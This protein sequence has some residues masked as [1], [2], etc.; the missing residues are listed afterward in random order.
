MTDSVPAVSLAPRRAFYSGSS[1]NHFDSAGSNGPSGVELIFEVE[2][3]RF[4]G[5]ESGLDRSRTSQDLSEAEGA[6]APREEQVTL[7]RVGEPSSEPRVQEKDGSEEPGDP[8]RPN[9]DQ[10]SEPEVLEQEAEEVAVDSRVVAPVVPAAVGIGPGAAGI[11]QE[12]PGLVATGD[13]ADS[14]ATSTAAS[15]GGQLATGQATNTASPTIPTTPPPQVPL[16]SVPTGRNPTAA[17]AGQGVPGSG[18]DPTEVVPADTP[19]KTKASSRPAQVQAVEAPTPAAQQTATVL[20]AAVPGATPSDAVEPTA[21]PAAR[22]Q[23]AAPLPEPGLSQ[24]TGTVKTTPPEAGP[25][26]AE[27]PLSKSAPVTESIGKSVTGDEGVRSPTTGAVRHDS[28]VPQQT[29]PSATVLPIEQTVEAAELARRATTPTGNGLAGAATTAGA[30]PE[31][32]P[33]TAPHPTSDPKVQVAAKPESA[34]PQAADG[35]PDQPGK[36]RVDP[37]IVTSV[38]QRTIRADAPGEE[39][40]RVT[41]NSSGNQPGLLSEEDGDSAQ[42]DETR[43]PAI[44]KPLARA[45]AAQPASE[46]ASGGTSGQSGST[47]PVTQAG[48]PGALGGQPLDLHRV[49]TLR[50]PSGAAPRT[51]PTREIFTQVRNQIRPGMRELSIQ[52]KPA[53][54]GQLK[55]HFL[56]EGDALRVSVTAAR[57]EVV[58]ALKS[59]LS[60]FTQTLRDAGIELTSL[61]VNLERGGNQRHTAPGSFHDRSNRTGAPQSDAAA[62]SSTGQADRSAASSTDGA[63]DIMA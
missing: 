11:G 13:G 38:R 35:Q 58:A 42:R 6:N 45:L 8:A 25:V 19:G 14:T 44:P 49:S 12:D 27:P 43:Q 57:P 5:G 2:L 46:P 54:L 18:G 31:A 60:A 62:A 41:E 23:P 50:G 55:L 37:E 28:S 40:K 39:P 36:N 48:S 16:E 10:E 53:E 7:E 61:D 30:R 15:R 29:N 24:A 22:R 9:P 59:D 63:L 51:V 3:S 32:E 17:T 33:V 4:T 47:A 52:L 56:M 34:G 26:R 21:E 1:S 20:D